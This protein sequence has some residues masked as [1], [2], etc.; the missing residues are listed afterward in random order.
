MAHRSIA[1]STRRSSRPPGSCNSQLARMR[2][3]ASGRNTRV[4]LFSGRKKCGEGGFKSLPPAHFPCDLELSV[5]ERFAHHGEVLLL[6]LGITAEESP[7][8]ILAAG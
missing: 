2:S 4:R 7:T 3:R 8:I 1:S 6:K 5:S